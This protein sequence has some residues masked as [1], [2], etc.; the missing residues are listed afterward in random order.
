MLRSVTY[1]TQTRILMDNSAFDDPNFVIARGFSVLDFD[2]QDRIAEKISGIISGERFGNHPLRRILK[3]SPRSLARFSFVSVQ[4]SAASTPHTSLIFVGFCIRCPPNVNRS[5]RRNPGI[6]E[7]PF[8]P[9]GPVQTLVEFCS[10][11]RS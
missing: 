4:S 6:A 8:K 5:D 1:P 10:L 7:I 9:K 3:K 2:D 11:R